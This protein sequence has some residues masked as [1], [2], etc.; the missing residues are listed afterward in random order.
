MHLDR[1]S[2][3]RVTSEPRSS[4]RVAYLPTPDDSTTPTR[5]VVKA[6]EENNQ[7]LGVKACMVLA[8]KEK[9]TP[10][11]DTIHWFGNIEISA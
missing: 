9:K 5:L 2:S 10:L 4:E 3:P 1:A 11:L 6:R 7:A 8:A